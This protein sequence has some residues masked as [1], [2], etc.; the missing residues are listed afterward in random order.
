[1]DRGPVAELAGLPVGEQSPGARADEARVPAQRGQGR[2][3]HLDARLVLAGILALAGG[4]RFTL[5]AQ[6]SVWLDEAF[7]V[8][9]AQHPWRDIP[10]LLRTVDQ[11][12]PLY[13]MFMHLWIGA[14]GAG[15]AAIR[16][17]S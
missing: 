1:M 16:I 15:E 11:H 5:L 7:V 12:P 6:N 13:F 17:P 10:G 14:V 4:L 3:L 9:V 8:W 2:E